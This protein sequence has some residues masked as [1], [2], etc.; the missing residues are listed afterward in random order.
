M[1]PART[2]APLITRLGV[3]VFAYVSWGGR[4]RRRAGWRPDHGSVTAVLCAAQVALLRIE[5]ELHNDVDLHNAG[6]AALLD[7][8]EG[9]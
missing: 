5:Q 2:H 9:L 8:P 4:R 7:F 6:R 1:N 3:Q